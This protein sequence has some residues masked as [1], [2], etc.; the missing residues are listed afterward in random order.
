MD[1]AISSSTAT[2][3]FFE[4]HAFD[5]HHDRGANSLDVTNKARSAS[6]QERT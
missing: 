2:A 5:T 6:S 4:S 3:A 1:N